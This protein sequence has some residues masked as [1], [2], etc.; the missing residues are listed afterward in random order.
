MDDYTDQYVDN[1][2]ADLAAAQQH[3]P[4]AFLT[5][6]QRLDF[7]HIVPGGFGT[8]DAIIV[9][10]DTLTII[11]LKY[12]KGVKVDAEHNPQ[13]SLYALGALKVYG[14]IYPI[15]TVR[16]IIFQPRLSNTSVWETTVE[17]L[18]QWAETVVKPQ[19]A[20]AAHGVGVLNAGQWCQFCR[21]HASCPAVAKQFFDVV[22]MVDAA[23]PAAPEPDTLT[24][25]QLV[26]IVTMAAELKQW[27]TKV[28]DYALQQALG[29]RS[30]DGLKVVEG[31]SVRRFTDEDKV[32][33]LVKARGHDPYVTKLLGITA[34]QKLLG[35]KQFDLL[36]GGLLVK[37]AGK[38]TLVA[39][40]D[41]RPALVVATPENTFNVLEGP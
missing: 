13:M 31:R 38:P 26:T 11:D 17:Y 33:E 36:L 3:N 8:G 5:I 2:T 29:G 40:S 25:E 39:V 15:K 10:D 16:M 21:H 27:L 14:M 1:V 28:E 41:P 35:R 9:A 34:M 19:A 4:A 37:P 18:Q 30:F 6:E 7:S 20:Q 12:G 22:P 32:A 24:E 23:T